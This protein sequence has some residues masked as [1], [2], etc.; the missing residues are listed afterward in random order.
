MGALRWLALAWLIA[1]CGA[2]QAPREPAEV[3]FILDPPTARVYAEDQFVGAG[4]VLAR[5]NERFRPG[6]RHFTVTAD[7]YFPHDLEVDLP[8]G[9]TTIRLR[10]RPVPP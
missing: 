5:R 9:L 1:G 6:M 7:G 8:S 10:L 4:R 3:R 2:R